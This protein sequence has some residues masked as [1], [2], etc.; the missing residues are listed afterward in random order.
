[1][2]V[3]VK[4]GLQRAIAQIRRVLCTDG[5]LIACGYVKGDSRRSDFFVE[6]FGVRRGYFSRP[7]FKVGNLAAQ[8]EGFAIDRQGGSRSVA[9]FEATR[10]HAPR[11]SQR[12]Q[13]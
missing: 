5:K 13:S 2:I 1:M 9:C 6:H 4:I 11:S 12:E 3:G 7:F 10:T 8:F